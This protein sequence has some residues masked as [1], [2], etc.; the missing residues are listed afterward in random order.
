MTKK[1]IPVYSIE[2]FNTGNKRDFLV[3]VEP[4]DANRHFQVEYPHRHD[5]Y[6]IL[7]LTKG[8]G[9]HIIDFKK[10]TIQPNVIFFLAPGQVHSLELSDDV[11]GYIFLFT[12]EFYLFNKQN[13]NELL[14]LP[15]FYNLSSETPPLYLKYNKD[16]VEF[17]DFFTKAST[18]IK[19]RK[20]GFETAVIAFLDLILIKCNR[21]YPRFL[22]S[23]TSKKG[24]LLVKRFKQLIDENY[25]EHRKVRDYAD[26]LHITPSHLTEVVKELTGKSSQELIQE[27]LIIES[28]KL[29]TY[30]ELNATQIA[31]RLNFK[32]QSYFSKFFK[33][34]TNLT[35]VQFQRES[36]KNT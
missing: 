9:F 30:T 35:P 31:F 33:K 13:K 1:H 28:K 6:E 11:E 22:P 8:S 19:E 10:Y 18:E 2:K 32:D 7:F 27:K 25:Q 21:L 34:H 26:M 12:S 16:I 29:L 14:E 4:F 36:G 5:F 17:A 15:F 24:K 20:Q 3:Q 23:K